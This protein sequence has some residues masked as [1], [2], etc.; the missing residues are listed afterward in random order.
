MVSEDAGADE[1]EDDRGGRVGGR[2]GGQEKCGE[3]GF[4]SCNM[5]K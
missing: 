5:L 2:K 1:W 4:D 3:M